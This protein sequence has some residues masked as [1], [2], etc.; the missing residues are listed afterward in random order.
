MKASECVKAQKNENMKVAS[1]ASNRRCNSDSGQNNIYGWY[2]NSDDINDT[3]WDHSLTGDTYSNNQTLF[4][5]YLNF[6]GTESN[7][8]MVSI[9]N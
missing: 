9:P 1:S 4:D 2:D 6:S 8:Q 5:I 7:I 3:I